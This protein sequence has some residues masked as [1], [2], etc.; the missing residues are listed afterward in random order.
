MCAVD[1]ATMVYYNEPKGDETMQLETPRLTLHPLTVE[2]LNGL[3][4][5][6]RGIDPELTK[7]YTDMAEGCRQHPEQ[8]LWYTAWGIYLRETGAM[9]GDADFKGLPPDGYP[10]IGYG[11]ESPYWGR[12]YATEAAGALCRWALKQLGVKGIEAETAP[13]NAAS[14]RVLAKLGFEPTGGIG[15]EGP[16]FRL[17]GEKE[18]NQ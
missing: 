2:E 9:I 12:G 1:K 11:L 8:Q 18:K 10:E 14:Q 13:D 3:V 15:E 6:Y 4:E 5:R 7:A 17:V 16:R